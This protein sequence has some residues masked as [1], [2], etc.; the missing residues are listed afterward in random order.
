MREAPPFDPGFP[1]REILARYPHLS[2]FFDPPGPRELMSSHLARLARRS[3][4][5][6]MGN[7]ID[8]EA[9]AM[10]P[11]VFVGLSAP[12]LFSSRGPGSVRPDFGRVVVSPFLGPAVV[13]G[14]SIA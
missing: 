6:A 7:G 8:P 13:A 9:V 11:A 3:Y 10:S 12:A 4:A 1:V 14:A 5:E 2:F